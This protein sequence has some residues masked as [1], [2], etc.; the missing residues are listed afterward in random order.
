M[1]PRPSN[2]V[3]AIGADLGAGVEQ[4]RRF[5]K[6]VAVVVRLEQRQH[7]VLDVG[8][9]GRGAHQRR[10]ARGP[11]PPAPDRTTRRR[12]AIDPPS[13]RSGATVAHSGVEF[14]LAATRARASSAASPSPARSRA[15]R[16]LL[17]RSGRR[18][19]AARRSWPVADRA[20]RASRAPR[21]APARRRRRRVASRCGA[22]RRPATD[23]SSVMRS[24]FSP[25][26]FS[27]CRARARC[28]R[29]CR[30]DSAAI[31]RKCVR[32]FHGWFFSLLRRRKASCTSAVAC[33]VCP[34]RSCRR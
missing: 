18:S 14:L 20:R 22:V 3:D 24:A 30:I 27:A 6:T 15:P 7:F 8:G 26:R 5:E 10:R 21:R 17:R 33:S 1:P 2:A 19:S 32:F 29:I 31:A 25:P 12:A 4:R 23:S 34:G 28:T 9:L 16:R 13:L 11:A